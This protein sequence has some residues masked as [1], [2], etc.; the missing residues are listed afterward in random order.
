MGEEIE[1]PTDLTDPASVSREVTI[2]RE[3]VE[4]CK[5]LKFEG[6]VASGGEAKSAVDAGRVRV[7][8]A[9]ERRR[10]RKLVDGDTVSFAGVE[11][12]LRLSGD[13]DSAS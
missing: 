6:L 8:G 2:A 3:P 11:L 4:L 13:T 9:L 7:N 1:R 5:V 12:R 10:R